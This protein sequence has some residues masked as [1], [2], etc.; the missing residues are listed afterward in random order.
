MR[1]RLVR[2][3][4]RAGV[5]VGGHRRA[6]RRLRGMRARTA[7][8]RPP[9]GLSGRVRRGSRWPR[10]ARAGLPM[11]RRCAS[12]AGWR[13]G[14]GSGARRVPRHPRAARRGEID[15]RGRLAPWIAGASGGGDGVGDEGLGGRVGVVFDRL[16]AH[17]RECPCHVVVGAERAERVDGL[18]DERERVLQVRRRKRPSAPSVGHL[19]RVAEH[20]RVRDG[21]LGALSCALE[22]AVVG[23][24]FGEQAQRRADAASILRWS[25]GS[26]KAASASA[27]DCAVPQRARRARASSARARSSGGPP[28]SASAASARRLPS[29]RCSSDQTGTRAATKR[30]ARRASTRSIARTVAEQRQRLGQALGELFG[31]EQPDTPRGQLERE[32]NAVEPATN[33]PHRGRVRAGVQIGAPRA[34]QRGEQRHRGSLGQRLH[35]EH[36]LAAQAQRLAAG[37]QY[38]QARAGRQQ[39]A[40]DRGAREQVLEVV[41]EHQQLPLPQPVRWARTCRRTQGAGGESATCAARRGRASARGRAGSA[42]RTRRSGRGSPRPSRTANPRPGSA[43]RS[44]AAARAATGRRTSRARR[45]A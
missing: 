2:E 25:A 6:V 33:R 12:R 34:R 7:R 31:L 41:D 30:I 44:R 1:F 20:L 37:G 4:G 8:R 43:G 36:L 3:P 42:R 9:V 14:A 24:V 26:A 5:G 29:G 13:G 28:G 32:R 22:V 17:R 10:R 23:V 45:R 21:G 11:G 15:Q 19:E 35:H 39:A 40:Q 18:R 16:V 27:R 38:P